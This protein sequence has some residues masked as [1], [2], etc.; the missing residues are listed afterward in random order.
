M[1]IFGKCKKCKGL[2]HLEDGHSECI[3][4]SRSEGKV[5]EE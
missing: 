5:N 3:L 4:C 1:V 2:I